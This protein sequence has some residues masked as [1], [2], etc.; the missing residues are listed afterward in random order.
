MTTNKINFIDLSD[1]L[2]EYAVLETHVRARYNVRRSASTRIVR[3]AIELHLRGILDERIFN[4]FRQIQD[5]WEH[6]FLEILFENGLSSKDI[7]EIINSTHFDICNTAVKKMVQCAYS[8]NDPNFTIWEVNVFDDLVY[9]SVASLG[10]YRIEQW[11]NEHGIAKLSINENVTLDI[12]HFSGFVRRVCGYAAAPAKIR[13]ETKKEVYSELTR[14]FTEYMLREQPLPLENRLYRILATLMSDSLIVDPCTVFDQI[15][16]YFEL[17]VR[18]QIEKVSNQRNVASFIIHDE[19]VVIN[20][21]TTRSLNSKPYAEL[22]LEMAEANGD[23]VPE[24]QR[25]TRG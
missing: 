23:Y 15:K 11:H 9:A 3:E 8:V 1:L 17:E 7:A 5:N 13:S 21:G 18:G 12:N 6:T 16:S 10:D 20:F 24:R 2:A 25:R 22:E 14:S 4:L 19:E